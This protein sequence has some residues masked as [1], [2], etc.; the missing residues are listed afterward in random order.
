MRLPRF[1]RVS[2]VSKTLSTFWLMP[3]PLPS[4]RR[5]AVALRL[6]ACACACACAVATVPSAAAAIVAP[7]G[8]FG[9]ALRTLA[10]PHWRASFSHPFVLAL[11]DGSL[12]SD[13]F[14]EYMLQ[15]AR[16]LMAFGDAAAL[17]SSRLRD[18]NEKA[19]FQRAATLATEV[20]RSLHMGFGAV[21][22][23][24]RE[25]VDA[26]TP[27]PPGQAY[28]D[29]MLRAAAT[30]GVLEALAALLP[31]PWLYAELGRH[32]LDT[33]FP[34]G[35]GV[36]GDGPGN[37]T[38][39]AAAAGVAAV[40]VSPHGVSGSDGSAAPASVLH[41]IPASHP[42]RAWLATYG[43]DGMADYTNEYLAIFEAHAAEAGWR[44]GH[45]TAEQLAA[46]PHRHPLRRAAA[47][48]ELSVRYEYA[49]WHAPWTRMRW[50]PES[51]KHESSAAAGA[52]AA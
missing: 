52:A 2:D 38:A 16:Y 28:A 47:A 31:C 37:G 17:L 26:L 5:S 35:G 36:E 50:W 40:D 20:E 27:H 32:L 10:D 44:P 49:F 21:L 42:Y 46:L 43:G 11:A 22:N 33:H 1:K 9:H 25:D 7:P 15:D 3:L 4:T 48:F 24:T 8:S 41:R 13:V 45:T 19:W 39:A 6:A 12:A 18:S 23:F 14:R 29:A 34:E 51:H 30:G